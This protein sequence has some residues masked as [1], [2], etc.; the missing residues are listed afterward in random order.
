MASSLLSWTI[1]QKV[2]IE[3]LR[4]WLLAS[5]VSGK[6]RYLD[7]QH[8]NRNIIVRVARKLW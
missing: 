8:G 3:K 2:N 6:S 7:I 1:N 4:E 5:L